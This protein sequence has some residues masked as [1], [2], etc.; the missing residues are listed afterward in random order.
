M[1]AII[2][3]DTP[4]ASPQVADPAP[5]GLAA[6]ALT[7]FL[8]SGTTRRSSP[9]ALGRRRALLRGRSSSSPGCGSSATATCSVRPRSPRTAGSGSALGASSRW[10]RLERFDA[11]SRPDL[12]NALAWFLI[13][14]AIF[15]TYML[16]WST[17]VNTA[18]LRR[19]PHA[20]DHRD[21]ARD[22]LLPG[23]ARRRARILHAGGWA[24]I[25]TAG[26]AWYTSARRRRQRDVRAARRAA[27]R[28][29][30]RDAPVTASQRAADRAGDGGTAMTPP[31]RSTQIR[32]CCS[33]SAATRRRARSPRQANAT[34][35]DLRADGSSSSG[36]G[37]ARAGRWFGPST[38]LYE[39]NP[40]YAKWYL[41]G[42]LNV[43]Y[44]CVDRHV[45]AATATRSPITG[46]ASPADE[47]RTLSFASCKRE[48]VRFANALR[49]S[50]SQK[51]TPVAIYMGMVP[52]AADRDA[53]VRAHR[54]ARIRSCSAGSRPR[55][56]AIA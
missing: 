52:E 5:L 24:G 40:P 7:T 2:E 54:R 17:R 48:V 42:K 1:A 13:A 28:P 46:R 23:R 8:L 45:E 14:F 43:C 36:T 12:N 15:N 30:W 22:R 35:G 6:F 27:G 34:A 44:N 33:R 49:R 37:G 41:G 31:S 26:V 39:W 25:V 4:P 3:I 21:P 9:T 50:A 18:V 47:R 55:R 38:K 56:C 16:L 11:L 19:L 20:R 29:L 51:G 53:R 10:S 32:R